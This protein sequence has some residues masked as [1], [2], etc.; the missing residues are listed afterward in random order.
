M[1]NVKFM[2]NVIIQRHTRKEPIDFD[3]DKG[4]KIVVEEARENRSF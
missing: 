3:E 1:S 4:I 2:E